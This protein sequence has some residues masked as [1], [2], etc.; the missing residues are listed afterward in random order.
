MKSQQSP[1]LVTFFVHNQ[2]W[3]CLKI[4]RDLPWIFLWSIVEIACGGQIQESCLDQFIWMFPCHWLKIGL[5]TR[6]LGLHSVNKITFSG[7]LKYENIW[8]NLHN[9]I[10]RFQIVCLFMSQPSSTQ[11]GVSYANNF[12]F[13]LIWQIFMLLQFYLDV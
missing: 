3:K 2:S 1:F 9:L 4:L 8:R 7:K 11:I 10:T 12:S 13:T 5:S 6:P